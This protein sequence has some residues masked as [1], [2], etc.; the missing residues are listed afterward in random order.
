MH[1]RL[2]LS[3]KAMANMLL[4]LISVWIAEPAK[5]NVRQAQSLLNNLNYKKLPETAAFLCHRQLRSL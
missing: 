2:A 1:V 4:M 5:A 3:A